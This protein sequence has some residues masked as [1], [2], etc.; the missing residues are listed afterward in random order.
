MVEYETEILD[1]FS[2][3]LEDKV[4]FIGPFL[5]KKQLRKIEGNDGNVQVGDY[6]QLIELVAESVESLFGKENA[7][8]IYSELNAQLHKREDKIE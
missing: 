6:Y 8:E 4:G 3:I 1:S 2:V 5:L 7:K